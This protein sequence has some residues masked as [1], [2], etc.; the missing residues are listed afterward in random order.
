MEGA[1]IV[2]PGDVNIGHTPLEIDAEPG[3]TWVSQGPFQLEYRNGYAA[4]CWA[5]ADQPGATIRL[6]TM[7]TWQDFAM[8]EHPGDGNWHYLYAVGMPP[9]DAPPAFP[10]RV[11]LQVAG[12]IA[13]FD[14]VRVEAIPSPPAAA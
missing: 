10:A 14:T 1:G 2:G 6:Q 3:E 4:G 5:K 11:K 8:A 7:D 9:D 13:L 12:G